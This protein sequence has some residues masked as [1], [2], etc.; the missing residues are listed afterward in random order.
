LTPGSLRRAVR[1]MHAN[2]EVGF[3][4]GRAIEFE[5]DDP[6]LPVVPGSGDCRY[7]IVAYPEFLKCACEAGQTGISSP[8]V[9]VRNRLHRQVG[10]YL[11]QLPHSGDT[12]LWL[13]LAAHA[14][15]GVLDAEQA[16]RRWHRANMTH[17]YSS[18]E[19]LGEQEAAF[20]THFSGCDRLPEDIAAMRRMLGRALASSAFWVAFHAF[21]RTDVALCETAL[22]YAAE[23]DPS[24][25][26]RPEWSRLRW[27]RVIGPK[28]WS[29]LRPVVEFARGLS[30][31]ESLRPA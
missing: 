3:T 27:K 16:Y 31:R 1:V 24:V 11:E 10:G 6:S 15:V 7:R 4:Y 18:I 28:A 9:L 25:R 26:S 17:N 13:R 22:E 8:T 19:R 2:P 14:A 20:D 21:D 5:T 12:E 23:T 30:P 29:A